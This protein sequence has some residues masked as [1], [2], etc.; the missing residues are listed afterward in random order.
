MLVAPVAVGDVTSRLCCAS[1]HRAQSLYSARPICI[2]WAS[3]L[4]VLFRIF[5]T[6]TACASICSIVKKITSSSLSFLTEVGITSAFF[7][8]QVQLCP[9]LWIFYCCIWFPLI[10]SMFWMPF[11][12]TLVWLFCLSLLSGMFL[13][14]AEQQFPPISASLWGIGLLKLCSLTHS[15]CLVR[16]LVALY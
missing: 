5:L 7:K 2:V 12:A 14:Q 3:P 1:F 9:W 15:G 6:Q 10:P 13:F 4:S 11:L 16:R 8:I